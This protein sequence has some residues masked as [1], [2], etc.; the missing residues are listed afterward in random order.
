MTQTKAELLQTRHQGDLKLGDADSSHYVGFKAPATVSSSLVWV[1][2]AADGSASQILKTDGSGNLGWA[3]DSATDSTKMPLAGGIFTGDVTFDGATAGRDIVFDRSDN[4][5]EFADNAKATFG[6][7]NDLTIS[8]D[9]SSSNITD[10]GTGALYL[11]SSQLKINNAA[12]TEAML[13][14]TENGAVELFHDGTKRFETSGSGATITGTLVSDGL[15]LGD[16]E[17]LTLGTGNDFILGHSGSDSFLRNDIGELYIRADGIRITNQ[18]NDETYIKCINDGA[19]ELYHNNFRSF[20]TDANGITVYGPEGG[21][22][23]VALYADEGDDDADKWKL[24]TD[25]SGNFKVSNKSTGSWVD[26]LTLN[27]SNNATF[28][29]QVEVAA[30]VHIKEGTSGNGGMPSLDFDNTD[31]SVS[32]GDLIGSIA[33]I[34]QTSGHAGTSAR[35]YSAAEDTTGGAGIVFQ[36]GDNSGISAALTLSKGQNATFGAAIYGPVKTV[37]A[38]ELNL[39]TGNYFIKT[40]SGNSTFTFANPAASGTVTAFTLELT[41][42]SGTVTWPSSVKWNADTAPTLTTGKTHLFMFVTDDGGTR[43]RGSALV[44]YVN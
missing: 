15:S 42:S 13:M 2:P 11:N 35:I 3:T 34:Q 19:V 4:A 5:L 18:A 31:T 16:N 20:L 36:T 32:T 28:A 43:Y 7:S 30:K 14:A 24:T 12:S 29:G 8:H 26:G 9:G 1:L 44:D 41:H 22:C 25:T 38:L 17:Y 33:F 39:S 23:V 6:T 27:G 37:S 10:S 21:D 40:I